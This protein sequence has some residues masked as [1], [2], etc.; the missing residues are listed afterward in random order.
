MG[1]RAVRAWRWPPTPSSAEVK[2]RVELYLYSP[3]G[4]SW[5]V[6]GWPLSLHITFTEQI[7][8]RRRIWAIIRLSV[9][10]PWPPPLRVFL[11]T[12]RHTTLSRTPLDEWSARR[13]DLYL[14]THNT[15]NRQI[16]MSP[17]G[18]EP[19]IPA[20][21]RPQ[22]HALESA[23][24]GTGMFLLYLLL[25]PRFIASS[26]LLSVPSISKRLCTHYPPVLYSPLSFT[27]CIL[28]PLYLLHVMSTQCS[29][30]YV[31]SS[32]TWLC[33]LFQRQSSRCVCLI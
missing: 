33:R 15:H 11:I 4:L 13:R 3:S 16:S 23:A 10:W 32:L 14:T 28:F 20:G 29:A 19:T 5:P 8:R 24:T 25:I 30:L 6:L 12:L 18:F 31:L 22:T 26:F 7:W 27:F 9:S 1:G 21:E 2:E 17:V